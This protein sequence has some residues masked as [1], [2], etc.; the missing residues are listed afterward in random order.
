MFKLTLMYNEKLNTDMW[1]VE[2]LAPRKNKPDY[3]GPFKT[4]C[5]AINARMV[6]QADAEGL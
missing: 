3:Y 2:R 4:K 6:L 5:S 1:H